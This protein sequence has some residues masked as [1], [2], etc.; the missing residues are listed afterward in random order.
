[1]N[2]LY[3]MSRALRNVKLATE[4]DG[5]EPVKLLL[6]RS[7][8]LILCGNDI[9]SSPSKK[10]LE[11]NKYSN[12]VRFPSVDGIWPLKLYAQ[13]INFSAVWGFQV[14]MEFDH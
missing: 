2:E 7:I 14:K 13:D 8:V 5:I 6:L 1:M 3:D 4:L 10:L 11:R 12:C 9:E